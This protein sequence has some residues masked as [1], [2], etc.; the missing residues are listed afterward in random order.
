MLIRNAA[1][2]GWAHLPHLIHD[3]FPLLRQDQGGEKPDRPA[4]GFRRRLLHVEPNLGLR[5]RRVGCDVVG[6]D[7]H[8]AVRLAEGDEG[9]RAGHAGGGGVDGPGHPAVGAGRSGNE[10]DGEGGFGGVVGPVEV[11]VE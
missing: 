2:D 4:G 8:L 11:R 6:L 5:E 1:G 9:L 7:S 10:G 3:R